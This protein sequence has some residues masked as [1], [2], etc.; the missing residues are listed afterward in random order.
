MTIPRHRSQAG[1]ALFSAGFR[2]FFLMAGLW[3]MLAMPLWLAVFAG[4]V[5]LPS[6]LAPWIWHAHE[7]IFGYAAAAIAGFLL[8][9]I[10]N[11]T[12]RLPLQGGPLA[13]LA[14]L[15]LAG[16]IAVMFSTTLG[17]PLTAALDLSFPLVFALA[18][19]REI[20]AGN[21]RR[22]LP[23]VVA[24]AFLF[25]GNLLVH[26]EAL[27]RTS[28]A[29]LGI[30][31][32]LATVLMLITL[33]GGRIIPS[34]TRNWLARERPEGPLP[35]AASRFDMA[36]LAVTAVAVIAWAAAPDSAVAPWIELAAGTILAVRLARWRGIA[37]TAEPLV[38]VLHVGY[39]WLAFG[40]LLL[41]ING[42]SPL[43]PATSALH[44]LTT[45]AVGTMTL[46]VMTRATLGHTGQLLAAGRGTTAI[47][48]LVTI[49]AVLRVAAPFFGSHYLALI[50]AAGTAWSA[51]FLLFV[52]L[53]GPL[54]VR[55]REPRPA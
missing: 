32:G 13:G 11:W 49:A 9:A 30:R 41:A 55:P 4:A 5:A 52:A 3:A 35:A 43:L 16:R 40:L 51:A 38:W 44:A 15:W 46:A 24:L 17:G 47:Y 1:S 20:I 45:G 7:M 28:T 18:V 23:M 2:P 42:L 53:Y 36:A 8:T 6:N 54:L 12:G 19:A 34:F 26:L 33:V 50:T 25:V 22:N 10:P 31:V 27:G 37:T 14:A 21:N 48:G 39:A 29:E